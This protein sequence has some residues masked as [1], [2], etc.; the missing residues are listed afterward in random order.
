MVKSKFFKTKRQEKH[1]KHRRFNVNSF[2]EGVDL[3]KQQSQENSVKFEEKLD[4]VVMTNINTKSESIKTK[5]KVKSS[6]KKRKTV[7]VMITSLELISELQNMDNVIILDEERIKNII[8]TKEVPFEVCVCSVAALPKLAR[9]ARYLGPKGCMPNLQ[10][11]TLLKDE[12]DVKN[13]VESI[14]SGGLLSIKNNKNGSILLSLGSVSNLNDDLQDTFNKIIYAIQQAKP[15]DFKGAAYI[16]SVY[17]N[18]TMG[19]S[20]CKILNF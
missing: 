19:L 5:V 14:S 20:S 10:N 11:G 4:L 12:T 2:G 13:T 8:A 17:I 1:G 15:K 16:K 7:G 6:D 18:T 9:A 3:L